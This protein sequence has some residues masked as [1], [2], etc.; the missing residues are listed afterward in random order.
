MLSCLGQRTINEE[1]LGY[2]CFGPW[3]DI[4]KESQI[5]DKVSVCGWVCVC[6]CE[7]DRERERKKVRE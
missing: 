6:E 3:K 5:L 1:H 7:C 2:D 4:E